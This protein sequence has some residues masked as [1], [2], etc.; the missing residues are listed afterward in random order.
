M[1]NQWT[2]VRL[3][4]DSLTSV[5][6]SDQ[7]DRKLSEN[8]REKMEYFYSITIFARITQK[9]CAKV[10][11]ALCFLKSENWIHNGKGFVFHFKILETFARS[12]QCY[13]KYLRYKFVKIMVEYKNNLDTFYSSCLI[14]GNVLKKRGNGLRKWLV[15]MQQVQTCVQNG[16]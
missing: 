9:L 10:H 15:M 2:I 7:M 1:G 4:R 14:W 6:D 3:L 13:K 5:W 12:K 11:Y 8:E 16:F